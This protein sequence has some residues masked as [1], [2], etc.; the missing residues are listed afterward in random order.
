MAVNFNKYCVVDFETNGLGNGRQ[1]ISIG[2]V[3]ID[4]RRLEI[5]DNGTFYS[6]MNIIDDDHVGDYNL[7]KTEQ[8]ALDVN[9]ISMDELRAA[10]PIK[11]VWK[12]FCQWVNFHNPPK[13]KWDAPIFTGFNTPFDLQIV[14]RIMDGHLGGQIVLKNKLMSK[15]DQKAS[16]HEDL[17]REYKN[18]ELVKEPWGFGPTW[19]FHPAKV[20]DVMQISHI[21]FESLREP[22][23]AS[24]DALKSFLGF[25]STKSHNALID[26]LWTAEIL[27]RHIKIQREISADTDYE[28]GGET[29]L[30]IQDFIDGF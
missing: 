21:L 3:M 26:C 16:S 19:L 17:A 9:K 23:N 6:T 14:N 20:V 29:H 11:K 27:I 12:D 13:T 15:K 4:P 30:P 24:L 18:L 25:S 1:P 22:H 28:T 2:A 10:P 8:K 7:D 5:C